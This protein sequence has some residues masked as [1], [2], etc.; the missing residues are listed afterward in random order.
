[1]EKKIVKFC[2]VIEC[3]ATLKEGETYDK[4]LL[5]AVQDHLTN[6]MD[7][8]AKKMKVIISLEVND[9]DELAI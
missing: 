9:F 1:M 6:I 3:Q 4:D 2:G 8:Y 7:K 5:V